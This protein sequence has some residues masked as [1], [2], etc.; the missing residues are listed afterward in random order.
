MLKIINT[1][2]FFLALLVF[3]SC[4]NMV[5]DVEAPP[6]DPKIVVT[7]FISPDN[8]FNRIRVYMSRPLYSTYST[9]A[10]YPGESSTEYKDATVVLSDGINTVTIDYSG[11]LNGYSVDQA[12]FPIV[13]GT[14]YYLKVTAPG[15]F[16]AE[17]SCT[18]P[19]DSPPDIEVTSIDS[20]NDFGNKTIQ[21]TGRYKDIEGTGHNYSVSVGTMSTWNWNGNDDAYFEK[22]GFQNGEYYI[23]DEF[24]DNQFF[25]FKTYEHYLQ[26]V[27]SNKIY[28]F[29]ALTDIDFYNYHK[30]MDNYEGDNPF[31][32]PTP[33]YSNITGGV[34]IFAAYNQ[35]IIEIEL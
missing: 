5:T 12:D 14:T 24:N 16:L 25:A 15:G 2:L 4:E 9:S 34:G 35:K 28:L 8:E 1:S 21:I 3:T 11:D 10:G 31:S 19:V 26:T 23:T 27:N 33:I 17:S 18:V 13:K 7:G 29:L 32:E 6:S 30:G 22:I 20:T